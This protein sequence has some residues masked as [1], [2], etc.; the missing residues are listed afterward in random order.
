MQNNEMRDCKNVF[1]PQLEI[2]MKLCRLD[3][4]EPPEDGD[5]VSVVNN[6]RALLPFYLLHLTLSLL[7]PPRL[8]IPCLERFQSI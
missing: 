5:Q 1:P 4:N 3:S 8:C 6:V 7:L 2:S